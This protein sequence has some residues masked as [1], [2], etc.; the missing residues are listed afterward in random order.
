MRE[1]QSGKT[2]DQWIVDERRKKKKG[3]REGR[4]GEERGKVWYPALA[5]GSASV[6]A[7]DCPVAQLSPTSLQPNPEDVSASIDRPTDRRSV[8]RYS[9]TDTHT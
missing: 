4:K 1:Q 9:L 3:R 8:P 7:A 6:L 5:P 2:V